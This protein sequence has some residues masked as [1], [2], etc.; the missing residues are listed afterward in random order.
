[1]CSLIRV[2]PAISILTSIDRVSGQ[3]ARLKW[4]PLTPDEAR[5]ILTLLEI[6]YYNEPLGEPD[7]ATFNSVDSQI[8]R[9]EESLFEQ[10]TADIT[11][12][13]PNREYCVAIQFSTSEGESGYSSSL[14]LSCKNVN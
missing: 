14:K 4:E 9:V 10:S 7:C 11:G 12:L 6:A 3:S 5:G 13:E 2:V 8:V 1:M